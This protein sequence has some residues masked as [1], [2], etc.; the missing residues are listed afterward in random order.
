M[1]AR[2]HHAPSISKRSSAVIVGLIVFAVC[3]A[4]CGETAR[5]VLQRYTPQ[6]NEKRQEFQKISG[7]LPAPGSVK[8]NSQATLSPKPV[9]NAKDTD[10]NNTEVVMADQLLDPDIKRKDNSNLDVFLSGNL[11][12]GIQWVG[13]KSSLD[14]GDLDRRSNPNTENMI[15]QGLA[16]RYIVVLR[17]ARYVPPVATNE[18]TYKAGVADIEGFVVDLSGPKVVGSFRYTAQSGDTVEYKAKKTDTAAARQMD[19]ENFAYSSLYSDARK[20]LKPLL[21]LSTGGSFTFD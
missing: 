9:L 21:E 16:E 15:K 5:K 14:A 2:R 19:L 7:L 13:P 18:T 17:P 4:S 3:L 20:K 1:L 10:S 11:L 6:L 12:L 8:E